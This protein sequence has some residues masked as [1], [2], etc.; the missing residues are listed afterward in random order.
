MKAFLF[1]KS[2]ARL[3]FLNILIKPLWIFGVDRQLQNIV[4]HEAYGTYFSLLN[5]SLVFSFVT[6]AGLSNMV[7][8]QL[9]S[10]VSYHV[11]QLLRIKFFLAALY[12]LLVLAIAWLAGVEQWRI[13]LLVIG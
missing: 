5:L 9:A 2:L 4:G 12:G 1:Y 7:N 6:D 3:L 11:A 8:R 10:G 13:L